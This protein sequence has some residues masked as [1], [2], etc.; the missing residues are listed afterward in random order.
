[1]AGPYS[2]GTVFLEVVPS[3]DKWNRRITR[4]VE[5]RGEAAGRSFD[6]GF[7]RASGGNAVERALGPER[8]ATDTAGK[9][10]SKS[11]RTFAGAFRKEVDRVIG[12][13]TSNLGK[14][15]DAETD[16]IVKSLRKLRKLK[17]G[18]DIGAGEAL[19]E[20]EAIG[21][22]ARAL[23]ASDVDIEVRYNATQVDRGLS[24]TI[25]QLGLLEAAEPTIAPV[26]DTDRAK[27]ELARLMVLFRGLKAA[28]E[29]ELVGDESARRQLAAI[30]SQ[31]AG[32]DTSNTTVEVVADVLQARAALA[33][34][35]NR[36]LTVQVT[37][38]ADPAQRELQRIMLEFRRLRAQ[39][40]IGLVGDREAHSELAR[41]AG[42]LRAID[43]TNASAQVDVDTLAAR[44]Q[45]AALDRQLR[46]NR[47][48]AADTANS[49]RSFS[50]VLLGVAALGPLVVPALAGVVGV[51]GAIGP[52]AIGAG[53][54]L[55]VLALGFSGLGDAVKAMADV[56]KNAD[57][58][59]L[60]H[61]KTL[62]TASKSIESAERSL[63]S[64]RRSAAD[65]AVQAARQVEDAQRGLADAQESA[66]DQIEAALGRQEDAERSLQ[67][68]Q[69]SAL[70][71]QRA[72]ID[73][74][75]EAAED[76]QDLDLNV[77]QGSVTER[78][79]VIDFDEAG[80]NLRAIRSDPQATAREVEEASIA[81]DRA[82][83]ALEEV[84]LENG[85]LREEQAQA[86]RNGI[87][88]SEKVRT[89]QE[90]ILDTTRAQIDAEREVREAAEATAEA[91]VAG[92]RLVSDALR[93]IDDAQANAARSQIDSAD[94]V[95][96]A[97]DALADAQIGYAEALYQTGELGSASMQKLND[98]MALLGPSGQAFATF[99]FSL[100]DEFQ[101]LRNVAQAGLLPGVQEAMEG[102][103]SRYGPG[104]LT[105]VGLMASTLGD[106][107]VRAGEALQ[108]PIWEQ[109]FATQAQYAPLFVEQ[110]SMIGGTLTTIFAQLAT[111]F[112][113]FSAAFNEAMLSILQG[114]SDYL[115]SKEGQLAL[116]QFIAYLASVGPE[117]W[118]FLVQLG[119]ALINLAVAIAP[120]AR[121]LMNFL[122]GILD[123]V[124]E[125]DPQLLGQ[126]AI[127]L[128]TM[129]VAFQT[130]VGLVSLFASARIVG[131][132]ITAL[133]ALVTVGGVGA[134][135]FLAIGAAVAGAGILIAGAF[136]LL[137]RDSQRFRD[138]MT[139]AGQVIGEVWDG[140]KAAIVEAYEQSLKPALDD[141]AE[142]WPEIREGL[143]SLWIV[144]EPALR[145]LAIG[146]GTVL[147]IVTTLGAGILNGIL[148]ALGPLLTG[149]ANII[150]GVIQILGGLVEFFAGVFTG[151]MGRAR[152]GV[153]AIFAG[154]WDVLK[155]LFQSSIGTI[156]GFVSGFVEGVVQFA[157]WLHDRLG[158]DL[159]PDMVRRMIEQFEHLW[160]RGTGL[161]QF[162]SDNIVTI[163]SS[164]AT[165]VTTTASNLVRDVVG[166]FVNLHNDIIRT[167]VN[168]ASSIIT[169]INALP[170]AFTTVVSLIQSAWRQL[171]E[172]TKA[173]IRF[174]V[175]TVINQGLFGAF[176][177]LVANLGLPASLALKPL[178]LPQGFAT[179]G[180][181][182]PGEK[183]DVAGVVHRDEFVVNK[184]SR[185]RFEQ[186]NPGYLD[187]INRFGKLPGF[188]EGGLVAF[189]RL[190]QSK[191]FRVGEHPA[192]GGVAPVHTKNSL[193]YSGNAIDVNWAAG[194][195]VAEQRAIDAIVPLAAQ[196][197]LRTIWRVANHHN[198]AHFDT[199]RSGNMLGRMAGAA[200]TVAGNVLGAINPMDTLKGAIG[201]LLPQIPGKG[202][203]WG[204]MLAG[205]AEKMASMLGDKAT[206]AIGAV[207]DFG[208]GI[209]DR[210]APGTG[211]S[212]DVRSAVQNVANG[213]G[214]G[215]GAQWDA[216]Q[217]LVQK[218]SS[219]NPRAQN[220]TS[221]AYGL[222]QFLNSTWAGSGY[223]KTSD[224]AQQTAAGLKYI[225][226]R[227]GSPAAAVAFHRKNNWYDEG[228][229]VTPVDLY[230]TGGVVPPGLS[231]VLNMTGANEH[232]AV[233]TSAQWAAL[234]GIANRPATAPSVSFGEGAQF[235]SYDPK[236]IM[237][238][239]RREQ[240]DAAAMADLQ[241]V[242]GGVSF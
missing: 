14:G 240:Q 11:G 169:A 105:F 62:R 30:K 199:G 134:S 210:I 89:A 211:G 186:E 202:K 153:E 53:S 242:V 10:G 33:Q 123:F 63:A 24:T 141:L 88:G 55:G 212:A 19:A 143:E 51:L 145:G 70:D 241:S 208:A 72:L 174:V 42:E 148:G 144:A 31:M 223:A 127:A 185:R 25:A 90:R 103:V 60:A 29:L 181:T 35:E 48:A 43:T 44:A 83:L 86:T 146:F 57:K 179:G 204:D 115:D 227:Y 206:S 36:R 52:A 6:E 139:E 234:E 132:A 17:I 87:E 137:N 239:F 231:G 58:D 39:I 23:S 7:E 81:Y 121:D 118:Q 178:T 99:L 5:Q 74:R 124:S 3:F 78:A 117:V 95:R 205:Y 56:Q 193:H 221:T 133:R 236:D 171:E 209:L 164:M 61:G 203:P 159:I 37:A 2:A 126:I 82:R 230:D 102:L 187:Y 116:T 195:S 66:A 49:F 177:S 84:R 176:N 151:D 96:A 27:A 15:V 9:R 191:G 138:F 166:F 112:A 142:Q 71:A 40:E 180:W 188:A 38:D 217:W 18:V 170:G 67:R 232:M 183:Y 136:Y 173:P 46:Q 41:L 235:Y 12:Q 108:S 222:F 152:A 50:G 184:R 94:S 168:M 64:A 79:A 26:V 161:F 119:D 213:Y 228:G 215:S 76:L 214:W 125:M 147:A 225:K 201:S 131:T 106:L 194:T 165:T 122:T 120:Y 158:L 175:N 238:E 65:S 135:A 140:I 167:V 156:L 21:A 182:G 149:V 97:Q 216:L 1:M 54:G 196:Y 100:R 233:F 200:G 28:V 101:A 172:A 80:E 189:G 192:F 162:L 128:I 157:V 150:G 93:A 107:A 92:S 104:L 113:P 198:H 77:R 114:F 197:G 220:P 20:L 85:R 16:A 218:E 155:G 75:R 47:S 226:D 219:W 111:A 110:W 91:R 69:E 163:I 154:L 68:A 229:R 130:M 109:F 34:F 207:G 160:E 59:A 73:A 32:I 13:S 22:R 224:P 237:S 190:L 45:L 4:E 129:I 98:A 8:A